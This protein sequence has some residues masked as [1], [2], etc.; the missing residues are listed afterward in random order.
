MSSVPPLATGGMSREGTTTVVR[1]NR[2]KVDPVDKKVLCAAMCQCDKTPNIGKDGKELK[3]VCVAENLKSF[4]KLLGHK[5]FYKEELNFDMTQTPPSP[6]MDSGI[7]TKGHEYLKGWINKY[8]GTKP[9]HGP[10]FVPRSG[11]IRRPD[12]VIVHDPSK[13]PTQDNNKQIV[14]M[15]FPPDSIS[16][17]QERAYVDIAGGASK[18]AVLEPG[19]CDCDAPEPDGPRIPIKELGFAAGVAAWLAFILT[20]GKTPR[21]PLVPVF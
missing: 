17:E 20:R 1:L 12:V 14:E 10:T 16:D 3:Q 11:L 5:S 8:W 19:D 18:L 15:K 7:I 21:P 6:I 2:V 13:P 9:E 4:D